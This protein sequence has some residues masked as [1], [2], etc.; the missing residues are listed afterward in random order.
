MS[1]KMNFIFLFFLTTFVTVIKAKPSQS[2]LDANYDDYYEDNSISAFDKSKPLFPS[3]TDLN[4]LPE[5]QKDCTLHMSETLASALK[6]G[7]HFD[8]FHTVC[9]K[10][11]NTSNCIN[12]LEGCSNRKMF[13]IA[14]SG[15][16]F[17]CVEKKKAFEEAIECIDASANSVTFECNNQCQTT[18]NFAKWAMQSGI[19]QPSP[20][21]KSD[22]LSKFSPDF[23]KSVVEG[24]CDM[25]KCNLRC[26]KNS[27]NQKCEKNA[28][29]LLTETFVRP[30]AEG[31]QANSF[32]SFGGVM[33][34]FVP[35]QCTFMVDENGLKDFRIDPSLD[36]D[37]K[38]ATDNK[39]STA[40]NEMEVIETVV[41][42]ITPVDPKKSPLDSD[43]YKDF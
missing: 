1:V 32:S 2:P 38:K 15:L 8:R 9:Q 29:T 34:M 22:A 41:K 5:C 11:T 40:G 13:D 33:G 42:N 23:M 7:N 14:T 28:G 4:V 10:Y 21:G 16:K 26:M 27:F 25:M 20:G 3:I 18:T 12:K 35:H 6:V 37:L 24:G 19:F 36:E 43:D 39:E 17:M 31:Q 30:I